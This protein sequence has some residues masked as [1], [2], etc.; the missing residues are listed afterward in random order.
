MIE[1]FLYEVDNHLYPVYGC[2]NESNFEQFLNAFIIKDVNMSLF[3]D[4]KEEIIDIILN[5]KELTDDIQFL[6]GENDINNLIK[7]IDDNLSISLKNKLLELLEIPEN[8]IELITNEN[9]SENMVEIQVAGGFGNI[10]GLVITGIIGIGVYLL[11]GK[12]K[13]SGRKPYG[14]NIDDNFPLVKSEKLTILIINFGDKYQKKILKM[15][16]N[17]N[18]FQGYLKELAIYNDLRAKSRANVAEFNEASIVSSTCD[19]HG[20]GSVS[21]TIDGNNHIFNLLDLCHTTPL[22]AK[23]AP[24]K[25]STITIELVYLCGNY[26]EDTIDFYDFVNTYKPNITN[27]KL[28]V[29]NTLTNIS[30]AYNDIGFIHGDMKIDNVLIETMSNHTQFSK[31]IIF[32]LDFSYICNK[33]LLMKIQDVGEVNTYLRVPEFSSSNTQ[34]YFV[35]E[36][37]H[38]FDIYLFNM[39]LQTYLNT[40]Q[41]NDILSE[42]EV[43]CQNQYGTLANSF[44]YFYL[45][46]NLTSHYDLSKK[47]AYELQMLEYFSIVS[48]FTKF[49]QSGLKSASQNQ[50]Y[51]EISNL[52]DEQ[53]KYINP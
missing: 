36:F 5:K 45:I 39:S 33:S 4:N 41:I 42:I 28:A 17:P 50:I 14:V 21:L 31:S 27:I 44:K 9:E 47:K 43:M 6:F 34:N 16:I 11:S 30:L 1:T 53:D 2:L 7:I 19:K 35:R 29:F 15:S 3:R 48:N 13:L 49:K 12:K 38:F 37:L 24:A 8:P 20:N 23:C 51:I 32:D 52:F 26:Y 10:V 40:K 18:Y 22:L 46:Y 25:K